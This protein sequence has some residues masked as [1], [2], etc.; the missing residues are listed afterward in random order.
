MR[1]AAC[2]TGWRSQSERIP[3][4]LPDSIIVREATRWFEIA[5]A[6][7]CVRHAPPEVL[8][9][10]VLGCRCLAPLR[11]RHTCCFDR[12]RLDEK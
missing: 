2:L 11:R 9:R 8:S 5:R 4:G 6:Q 10:V 1:A 3:R 7:F 12:L